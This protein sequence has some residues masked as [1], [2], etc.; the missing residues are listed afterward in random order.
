MSKI[1]SMVFDLQEQADAE[2]EFCGQHFALPAKTELVLAHE[3]VMMAQGPHNRPE[4]F[5]KIFSGF[6]FNPVVAELNFFN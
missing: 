4:K 6:M 5:R 1:G 2:F 3:R